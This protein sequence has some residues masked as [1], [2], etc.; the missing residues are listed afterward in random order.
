MNQPRIFLQIFKFIIRNIKPLLSLAI[1]NPAQG[2]KRGGS[3]YIAI[4][5]TIIIS[6]LLLLITLG[7]S[8]TGFWGRLNISKTEFK[9]IGF[10]LAEGCAETALLKLSQNQ[11]YAGGETVMIGN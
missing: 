5:S 8:S 1:V 11:S 4:I 2:K 6:L 3:G 7:V 9:E 10:A